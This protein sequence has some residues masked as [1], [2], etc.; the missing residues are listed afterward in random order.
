MLPGAISPGP[1]L[2]SLATT[3]DGYVLAGVGRATSSTEAYKRTVMKLSESGLPV[4]NFGQGGFASDLGIPNGFGVGAQ[5]SSEIVVSR[6]GGFVEIGRTI[7]YN[8]GRGGVSRHYWSS[9]FR[10][11]GQLRFGYPSD[12]KAEGAT[13][14]EGPGFAVAV[15]NGVSVFKPDLTLDAAF[16]RRG[17]NSVA[18]EE[19][20]LWGEL[21]TDVDGSIVAASS[22]PSTIGALVRFLGPN[23]GRAAAQANIKG[24]TYSRKF[25]GKP[26]R[27]SWP[28]VVGGTAGPAGE[29]R[30]VSVAVRRIDGQRPNKDR[31]GWMIRS[32]TRYSRRS[33]CSQPVFMPAKGLSSWR[34]DFGRPL[35]PGKYQLFVRT[36]MNDGR[37]NPINRDVDAFRQFTVERP[38]KK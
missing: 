13:A 36:T 10:A 24:L 30:R 21:A 22:C 3:P 2:S 33:D 35:A 8:G 15:A 27:A 32:A 4:V 17:S 14:V 31:C 7:I 25:R 38:T 12:W 5:S 34:F 28:R 18:V 19:C 26:T 37:V 9:F 1:G 6:D 29:V 11:D 20:S 16:G 23:G